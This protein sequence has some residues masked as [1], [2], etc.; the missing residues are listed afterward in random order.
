[1][2]TTYTGGLFITLFK[3]G[4]TPLGFPLFFSLL[5]RQVVKTEV[6]DDDDDD[7][8]PLHLPCH[9]TFIYRR[10]FFFFI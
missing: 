2:D 7:E 3:S 5:L 10:L 4:I 9:F 8:Y 1:M 6:I